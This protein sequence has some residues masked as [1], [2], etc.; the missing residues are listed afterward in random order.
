MSVY[1]CACD[2]WALW[3]G[4]CR[5]GAGL[6]ERSDRLARERA[7][8]KT[9]EER[10]AWDRVHV[11]ADFLIGQ[12]TPPIT[13]RAGCARCPHAKHTEGMGMAQCPERDCVC[14]G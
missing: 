12:P 2:P 1:P 14:A 7:A 13:F 10:A 6:A 5:C 11:L 9:D 4:A 3:Q 8:L